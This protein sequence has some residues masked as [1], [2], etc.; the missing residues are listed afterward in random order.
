[1][2][3]TYSFTRKQLVSVN[4]AENIALMFTRP[5]D[6]RVFAIISLDETERRVFDKTRLPILIVD[7]EHINDFNEIMECQC[8]GK[9]P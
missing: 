1:M 6:A 4:L 3:S 2:A 9:A 7:G 8:V 5:R